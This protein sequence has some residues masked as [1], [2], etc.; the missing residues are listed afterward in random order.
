MFLTNLPSYGDLKNVGTFKFPDAT[1][2][3]VVD[4][5]VPYAFAAAGFGLLVYLIFGGFKLLTSGGNPEQ[6]A[7]GQKML[8]NAVIG[9]LIVIAS[10]WLYQITQTILGLQAGSASP[11][12]TSCSGE[13]ASRPG[14]TGGSCLRPIACSDD[15][16]TNIGETADCQNEVICCCLNL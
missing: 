1:L 13:C 11:S 14:F 6:V 8:T 9:F 10:F 2:G 3:S 15:G 5:L 16:G 4:A 7:R 12:P